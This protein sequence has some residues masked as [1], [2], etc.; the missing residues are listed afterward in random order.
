MLRGASVVNTAG[1]DLDVQLAAAL[2]EL[3]CL[4]DISPLSLPSDWV[5][6][7]PFCDHALKVFCV[8]VHPLALRALTADTPAA[9]FLREARA[10]WA[11]V[12]RGCPLIE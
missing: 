5:T 3:I 12:G 9:E 6:V 7:R 4:I 10:R 1:A 2:L 11:M 8:L